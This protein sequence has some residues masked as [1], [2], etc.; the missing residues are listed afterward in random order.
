VLPKTIWKIFR[1]QLNRL[2][3]LHLRY[4]QFPIGTGSHGSPEIFFEGEGGSLSIGSYCSIAAGVKIFLAGEHRTRWVTTYPF[5]VLL[6][7]GS[8]GDGHS[9]TKGD[10]CIGN[11]VW[12]AA[13][14]LILS[15]VT[16]GDG[17]VIA[18]RAVVAKDVPPYSIVG[19]NPAK[20]LRYR[21]EPA[22]IEQLLA[23][24]WWEWS[25]DK[26]RESLPIMLTDDIET[27][28]HQHSQ[29]PH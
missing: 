8:N 27:F 22:T 9:L 19:G 13:D 2:K 11:D 29:R 1:A 5:N 7:I 15:G 14:A 28:L 4:P 26:I 16:I 24:R 12:I 23:I 6:N 10:V 3:P 20:V 25:E 18:A 21:F 17:A